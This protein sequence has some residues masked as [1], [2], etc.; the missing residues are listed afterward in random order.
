MIKE[1]FQEAIDLLNH[2][3]YKDGHF[4]DKENNKIDIIRKED[5]LFLIR[6]IKSIQNIDIVINIFDN[7]KIYVDRYYETKQREEY[8]CFSGNFEILFN[9]D[10]NITDS[11]NCNIK[12]LPKNIFD[13][14]EED[15]FY[16]RLKNG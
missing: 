4:F 13:W 8:T 11:I 6:F 7:V 9:S 2:Y 16:M 3:H 1:K 5:N 10:G 12:N 15:F 14:T